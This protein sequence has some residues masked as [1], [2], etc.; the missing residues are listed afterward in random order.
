MDI[1]KG[2]CCNKAYSE[3]YRMGRLHALELITDYLSKIS[4][5]QPVVISGVALVDNKELAATDSQQLKQAVALVRK[6]AILEFS[7]LCLSDPFG[8]VLYALE[9]QACVQ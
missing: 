3:G 7:D 9:Q 5:P 8:N 1:E 4:N 6:T 2:G